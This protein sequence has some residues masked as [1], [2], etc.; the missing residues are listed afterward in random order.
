MV[1][2]PIKF[3][4]TL[5]G[6]DVRENL[7]VARHADRIG[8]DS[9][10]VIETRLSTDAITPLAAYASVTDRIRV[11]SG[12]IPIWT[13]NPA[14]IAQT[15]ATL[16]SLAPGRVIM[17]LGAWWEPLARRTGVTREKPVR[18]MREV[19]ESVRLLL[20]LEGPVTYKGEYVDLENV[21]LDHGRFE[22]HKV[23]VYIGAVGPQM[24]RLAGR[25][26]DGVVL[27][28]YQTADAVRQQ[29]EEVRKG[30]ESAGR[31]LDEIDRVKLLRVEITR[32]K[33]KTIQDNKPRFAMYLA[34]QPHIQGPS[35]VDPE[36]FQ[37]VKALIPWPATEEQCL[38]A[39][40]LIPDDLIDDLTCFGDE[41]EVRARIQEYLAAGATKPIISGATKETIDFL[42]KGF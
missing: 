25:I 13:R 16:D 39:A 42:A 22:P 41:E 24:L 26:A 6:L 36:L 11:G 29:V 31:S 30:A 34:Q 3:G 17:G 18:A 10:W 19:I 21:Y 28:N 1:E 8:V 32:N 5:P 27:N 37:R 15:F 14:L 35:R 23:K 9:L 4:I 12:V 33:K 40:K 20:S 38:E 2:L 7:E